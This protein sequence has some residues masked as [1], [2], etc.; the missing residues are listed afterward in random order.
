VEALTQESIMHGLRKLGGLAGVLL[1]LMLFGPSVH[2]QQSKPSGHGEGGHFPGDDDDV[3]VKPKGG[4]PKGGGNP[5]IVKYGFDWSQNKTMLKQGHGKKFRC[6]LYH[7]LDKLKVKDPNDPNGP[8]VDADAV[9]FDLEGLGFGVVKTPDGKSYAWY[10]L[11]EAPASCKKTQCFQSGVPPEYMNG[12]KKDGT[13][14]ARLSSDPGKW[15]SVDEVR[16][17]GTPCK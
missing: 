7:Q 8:Y 2:S 6:D 11:K 13:I 16:M 17:Q 3:V 14:Q 5:G 9:H 12:T 15:V 4:I 10:N 1:C